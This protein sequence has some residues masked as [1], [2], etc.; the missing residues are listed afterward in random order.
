[1]VRGC[2]VC[3][4][5]L[6]AF[7]AS[8][9]L[10][11]GCA[12]V[13][14]AIDDARVQAR[15]CILAN[16]EIEWP[17]STGSFRRAL[18]FCREQ[19]VDAVVILGNLTRGGAKNQLEVMDAAWR[20]SFKGAA[21]TPRRI[22]VPGAK[23]A[24]LVEMTLPEGLRLETGDTPCEVNG[25]S[26]YASYAK[27]AHPGFLTFYG[28]GKRALTDEMC[29]Y[30]RSSGT[31]CAGS[32]NGVIVT[33]RW[34]AVGHPVPPKFPEADQ[35]VPAAQGLLVSVYSDTVEIARL[36][37]LPKVAEPVAAPWRVER[38][39]APT[40]S[41]SEKTAPQFPADVQLEV[42]RGYSNDRK[43]PQPVVTLRWPPA[44]ATDA[45]PRAFYYKLT[46]ADAAT[47]HLPFQTHYLHTQGFA[48]AEARDRQAVSF[49]LREADLPKKEGAEAPAPLVFKV[50]PY[51]GF[52]V[53]GQP[54][55]GGLE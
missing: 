44:R 27:K 4:L 26:F 15:I 55:T 5:S 23:D 2:R 37:F 7:A 24:R 46:V 11:C 47:P 19:K 50:T 20:E 22:L 48:Q 30:P 31:V 9:L 52:G 8:L 53:G 43:L 45:T 21:K 33:R 40:A 6:V 14:S 42:I 51:S 16:P 34:R 18:A 17:K 28:D 25:F 39:A 54:L 12:S 3:A 29:F 41:A 36:D 13:M 38:N 32:L 49:V 1:M 35:T 10:A